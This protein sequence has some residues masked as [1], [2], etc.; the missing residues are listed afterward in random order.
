MHIEFEH[1]VIRDWSERD[2]GDLVEFAN[3]REVWRN[4]A[5]RFPHPYTEQNA[6]WWV[7]HVAEMPMPTAWA[8]EVHNR[9][10]G[11]LGIEPREGLYARSAEF[12]YWLGKPYW[13]R[14]IAT[15]AGR[16]AL[17]E[18]LSAFGLIRLEALVFEWNAAS[19][20]VL[21]KLGFKREGWLRS[22]AVKNGIVLDQALYAYLVENDG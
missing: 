20:R 3:N 16:A 10:V 9:A 18:I 14:G 13:G 11:G 21:E 6:R 19:M 7:A 4:L 2:I 5:D 12:G 1:G 15:A 17:P 8:I 22:S